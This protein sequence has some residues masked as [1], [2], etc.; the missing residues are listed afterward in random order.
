MRGN[1]CSILNLQKYIS[2]IDG[3]GEKTIIVCT[4]QIEFFNISD[5]FCN[6]NQPKIG[7][8]VPN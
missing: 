8:G 6:R 1:Y 5:G 2:F 3:H 7:L 4:L